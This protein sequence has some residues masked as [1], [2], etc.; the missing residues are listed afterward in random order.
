MA[1]RN[2]LTYALRKWRKE[3][4]YL[5]LRRSQLGKVF[6]LPKWHP[7]HLVPHFLHLRREG[8]RMTHYTPTESQAHKD[9]HASHWLAW[10][11][12]WHFDGVERE[13]DD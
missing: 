8:E 13:G 10:L 11:R 9:R 1:V 12:L 3:G 2:C 4:G 5:V 7:L 6:R